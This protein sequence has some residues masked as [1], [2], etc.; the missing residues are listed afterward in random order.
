MSVGQCGLFESSG[1]FSKFQFVFKESSM[2]KKRKVS[3]I[4]LILLM[5]LTVF[6][7]AAYDTATQVEQAIDAELQ[8]SPT[9]PMNGGPQSPTNKASAGRFTTAVDDTLDWG[10]ATVDNWQ[11][12]LAKPS[13]EFSQFQFVLRSEV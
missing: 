10:G 11:G 7:L 4:G 2:M 8:A 13:G 1:V 3:A 9:K 5:V 12:G 6:P